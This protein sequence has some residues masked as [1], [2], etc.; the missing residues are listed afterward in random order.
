MKDLTCDI[1]YR[2]HEELTNGSVQ[3]KECNHAFCHECFEEYFRSM[4]E[5]QNSS[6]K[7][8]CP[9]Y[10]C[11]AMATEEEVKAIV[12]EATYAKYLRFQAATRVA[13][14]NGQLTF[15]PKNDCENVIQIGQN[16]KKKRYGFCDK[17]N[18][19]LCTSCKQDYHGEWKTCQ[20]VQE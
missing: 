17:C 16:K 15:C 4:I 9:S 6:H 11:E 10:G 8:K 13:Q 12:K 7:L 1:C 18:Y 2:D 14:S 3:L 5:E 20:K 19:K